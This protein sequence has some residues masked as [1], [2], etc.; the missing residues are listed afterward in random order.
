MMMACFNLIAVASYA[1]HA[2]G[3]YASATSRAS[4]E[5]EHDLSSIERGIINVDD[6]STRRTDHFPSDI[7]MDRMAVFFH[8]SEFGPAYIAY[9][10]A[11]KAAF[12]SSCDVPPDDG[13]TLDYVCDVQID[14]PSVITNFERTCVAA[15]G[16]VQDFGRSF[17]GL[18][19]CGKGWESGNFLTYGYRTLDQRSC[20]AAAECTNEEANIWHSQGM[21]DAAKNTFVRLGLACGKR[22]GCGCVG[23]CDQCPPVMPPTQLQPDA[24]SGLCHGYITGRDSFIPQAPPRSIP[25]G[26]RGPFADLVFPSFQDLSCCSAEGH[27]VIKSGEIGGFDAG[28]TYNVTEPKCYNY[29]EALSM[30]LCDPRQGDFIDDTT[31]VLRICRS[32]CDMVFDNCGLPGANFPPNTEYTNGTSLCYDLFGGFFNLAGYWDGYVSQ[33]GL[34]IEVIADDQNCID[35][36]VPTQFDEYG[37]GQSPDGSPDD[38]E[39]CSLGCVVGN[40]VGVIVGCLLLCS[41]TF[42]GMKRVQGKEAGTTVGGGYGGYG[43][44]G[45]TMVVETPAVEMNSLR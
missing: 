23:G 39:L 14:P 38:D 21:T 40:M 25:R 7:C 11:E 12:E 15:G 2:G 13:L 43:R 41:L 17:V 30:V 37:F 8:D 35:I 5:E 34:T 26:G 27:A 28:Y 19:C 9:D 33:S 16:M 45:G 24:V 32:S 22:C 44:V 31:N 6:S 36:V 20:I 1:M 29:I 3:C 10:N 4:N 18:E 42:L